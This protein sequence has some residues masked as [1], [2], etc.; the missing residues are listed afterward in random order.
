MSFISPKKALD[1]GDI[2][3][4]KTYVSIYRL[5]ITHTNLK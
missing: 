2:E 1:E 4:L 3:L 5:K